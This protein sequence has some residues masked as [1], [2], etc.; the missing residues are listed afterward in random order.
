MENHR[1]T[2]SFQ[3]SF[4]RTAFWM[5]LIPSAVALAQ[6]SPQAN[7]STQVTSAS[8]QHAFLKQYCVTCHSDKLR[9][10]GLSLEN[11]N[12]NDVTQSGEALEKVVRKVGSGAMPPPSMPRPD[13]ATIQAF[14]GSLET[15]LDQAAV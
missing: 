15:A 5:L 13:K 6:N 14:V 8:G 12:L 10:G 2:G 1:L 11:V 4:K 9:T 7:S 3:A